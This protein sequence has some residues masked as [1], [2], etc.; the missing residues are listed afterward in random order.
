LLGEIVRTRTRSDFE[1]A[2]A[3]LARI[4]LAFPETQT[5]VHLKI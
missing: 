1:R 3:A 2:L 4:Q 5:A